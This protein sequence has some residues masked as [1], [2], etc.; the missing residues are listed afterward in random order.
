MALTLYALDGCPWCEKVEDALDAHGLD[1]EVNW[2]EGLHSKR[3]EVRRVS[4]QRNV[5]VLVDADRGVTMAESANIV[6]Y[7]ERTL[8]PEATA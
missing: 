3:D 8:A 6:E 5:P 1:Y 2:V 4:G 7:V